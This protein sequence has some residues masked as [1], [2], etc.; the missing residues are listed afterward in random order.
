MRSPVMLTGIAFST[1]LM[2]LLAFNS[3][4]HETAP[5]E[6]IFG[7]ITFL[8][9]ACMYGPQIIILAIECDICNKIEKEQGIKALGTLS[10]FIDGFGSLGSIW[11]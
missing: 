5:S 8:V 10:G 4:Y 6:F 7:A 3:G 2:F 9:G 1:F 11:S